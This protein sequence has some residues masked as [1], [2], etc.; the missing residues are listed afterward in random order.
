MSQ[1]YLFSNQGC[2]MPVIALSVKL[3]PSTSPPT[4]VLSPQ[5]VSYK[6]QSATERKSLHCHHKSH[7]WPDNTKNI[8]IYYVLNSD[9]SIWTV[10]TFK[11]QR[12]CCTH[13]TSCSNSHGM[14][15]VQ[16]R[17]IL[18]RNRSMKF[19]KASHRKLSPY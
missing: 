13:F 5:G 1:Q 2:K 11:S 8:Q 14:V 4:S 17:C 16:A 15:S 6:G 9:R 3:H 10:T 18:S 7:Y 12:R 19:K